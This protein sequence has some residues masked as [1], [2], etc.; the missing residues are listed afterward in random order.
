LDEAVRLADRLFLLSSRPA[1]VLAEIPIRVPR[2][3]RTASEL[4]VAKAEIARHLRTPREA[5]SS[6]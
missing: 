6:P 4:T 5:P 3:R 1:Q 2:G